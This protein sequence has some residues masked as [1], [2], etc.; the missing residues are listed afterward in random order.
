MKSLNKIYF[1]KV[2]IVIIYIISGFLGIISLKAEIKESVKIDKTTH[3]FANK[4]N[5]TLKLDRYRMNNAT[6][7]QACLF[8][9]FGG[10]FKNGERDNKNYEKYFH[11]FAEN[12]FTVIS[13]DY[14]LGM[15]DQKGIGINN[16]KPLK[17]AINMAVEDL[18]DATL[19]SIEHANEWMIDTSLFIISGSSAG[20]IT[21]L[22]AEYEN[23][24]KT[25]LSNRLPAQFQY[26]GV[27]SFSGAIFSTNGELKWKKEKPCP[28]MLFHGDNDKVVP[29]N[30]IRFFKLGFF[31]SRHIASKL[32]ENGFFYHFLSFKDAA[33]EISWIPMYE[34]KKEILEFIDIFI[35]QKK[36]LQIDEQINQLYREKV[37]T[38]ESFKDLYK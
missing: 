14:R 32:N 4:E 36:A 16:Y 28:I 1:F 20:A 19:Y 22:Q 34:N 30:K 2:K 29:Y 11:F 26:A 23:R 21:V 13:I 15:K 12:G 24:N 5:N 18:F 31:G 8:F 9:V 35:F 6:Q 10:G 33:H 7:K 38:N 37:K 27:I 25:E 17:N 3:I